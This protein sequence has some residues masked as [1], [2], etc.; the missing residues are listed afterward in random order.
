M[1]NNTQQTTQSQTNSP[2][3]PDLARQG[4]RE[5]SD[6]HYKFLSTLIEAESARSYYLQIIATDFSAQCVNA[7]HKVITSG[8]D[9]NAILASNTPQEKQRRLTDFRI[10]LNLMVIECHESDIQNP[11]FLT[12]QRG[13]ENTFIDFISRSG[14]ERD[15][16]L[17]QEYGMRTEESRIPQ[18][19]QNTQQARFIGR[20]PQ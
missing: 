17:R 9:K 19:G 18:Q 3:M 8:F 20:Q 4:S 10:D 13:L 12:F 7:F 6:S 14:K 5:Y 2:T 15:Q 16:L 1:D 11:A